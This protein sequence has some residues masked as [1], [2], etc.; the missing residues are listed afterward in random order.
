MRM[1]AANNEL[2]SPIVAARKVLGLNPETF[3]RATYSSGV[4]I[5]T[6]PLSVRQKVDIAALSTINH[7][8][9][10]EITYRTNL[11]RM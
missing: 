3:R 1:Q 6:F 9:P 2:G 7:S 5:S 10:A 11:S 4:G 8:A